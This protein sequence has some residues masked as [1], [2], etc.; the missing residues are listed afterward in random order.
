MKEFKHNKHT[1]QHALRKAVSLQRIKQRQ[2]NLNLAASYDATSRAVTKTP[3]MINDTPWAQCT[4]AAAADSTMNDMDETATAAIDINKTPRVKT[5]WAQCTAPDTTMGEATDATVDDDQLELGEEATA[6]TAATLVAM[7]TPTDA[8]TCSNNNHKQKAIAAIYNITY[9]YFGSIGGGEHNGDWTRLLASRTVDLLLYAGCLQ[10]TGPQCI[11]AFVLLLC[12]NANR[13]LQYIEHLKKDVQL[14]PG[15][16]RIHLYGYQQL[17]RWVY[18]FKQQDVYKIDDTECT[19]V[20]TMFKN[21]LTNIGRHKR[22]AARFDRSN[23]IDHLIAN[24]CW[25]IGGITD[26][27]QALQQEAEWV[28]NNVAVDNYPVKEE[29]NRLLSYLLVHIL[30]YAPQG[31]IGGI[32]SCTKADGD[33]LLLEGKKC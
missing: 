29:Y 4:P 2:S 14:T 15:T 31:R 9:S 22:R 21:I 12:N 11:S 18:M 32:Q 24:R 19:R 23:D 13:F 1:C 25:P 26:I 27:K 33:R 17:F 6:A 16:I 7:H 30:T 28:N 3:R 10:T 20:T 5:P 8:N